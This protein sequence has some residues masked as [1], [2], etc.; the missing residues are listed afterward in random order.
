MNSQQPIAILG[1]G[2]WGT[3]LAI[4][5]AR[6]DRAVHLWGHDPNLMHK[7]AFERCNQRYLPEVKFPSALKVCDSLEQALHD[8]QDIMIVVPSHAIRAVLKQILACAPSALRVAWATKGLDAQEG[9]VKFIHE[10]IMEELGQ[11]TL[12]AVL[13]GPSFAKEVA[14]GLPTAVVIASQ[15]DRFANDLV[16]RFHS[17]KFRVYKSSDLLG[18]QICGAVK[19]IIAVA[20]GIADSLELGANARCALITR[21]L[22]EMSRLGRTLSAK[23]ETFMGLAGVGDL[24]LTCTSDL[25]RNRRFGLALGHNKTVSAAKEAVGGLIESIYNTKQIYQ[26]AT[27]QGIEMPITEQVYKILEQNSSSLEAFDALVSRSPTIEIR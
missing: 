3:A 19:N 24:L 8:V 10:V 16:S 12:T 22:A 14:A 1:A 13:S 6:Q 9:S 23:P 26:L 11:N 4:H 18:V 17:T 21:G 2:A 7:L 27:Q 15:S 25:S 20:A 5:L